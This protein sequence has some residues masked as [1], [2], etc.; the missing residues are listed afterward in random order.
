MLA[1]D[2]SYTERKRFNTPQKHMD[3]DQKTELSVII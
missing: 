2:D 1:F 3:V